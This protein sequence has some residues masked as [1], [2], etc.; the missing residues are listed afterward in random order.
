MR[1][2][3]PIS[4][5]AIFSTVQL[6]AQAPGCPNIDA[7]PDQNIN[8]VG[9]AQ[10]N[11]TVLHTGETNTY[12][13]SSIPYTPP[14]PF[15]T[16]TPILV[17]VDDTWSGVLNLPFNFCFFGNTYNQVV[18]GSNGCLTFNTAN[19]NQYCAWSFSV[20]C[21]NAGIISSSTGPYILGPYHDIDPAVG[22]S[23]YYAILGSYPCRTFVINYY[24]IPMF[25]G[26]C[27]SLLATHQ[28]VLYE[29]TNVVEVYIQNAPVCPTWNSG[30]KV[31]GI[32]NAAG[33][34][35]FTPP[36]RN[37]GPWS[38]S[39]EAWRFTPNGAPNYT[40]EWLL[41]GTQIATGSSTNVSPVDTTTYTAVCTYFNCDGTQ[42]VVT[43]DVTINVT[44]PI[45]LIVDPLSDTICAGESVT[46]SASGA[47]TYQW[48]PTTNLTFVSDSVVIV[49]PPVTT[50]YTLIVT[51]QGQTCTGSVDIQ[52]TV[53]P[54][55][56]VEALA[57]QSNICEGDTTEIYAINADSF[58]WNDMSTANPRLVSP[59]VTTTYTVTGY[60]A[61]GCSNTASITVNVIPIP[62]ITFNP[63]DPSICNGETATITATGANFYM[64]SN[65]TTSNP[66]VVSPESTTTYQVTGTDNTG[67]CSSSAEITVV[68]NE[69]PTSLFSALPLQGCA[70]LTVAF[71]DESLL[72][73]SWL[74]D[75]GDL[76]TSTQQ[77]PSHTYTEPG[78]YDVTL[79]VTSAD[80]CID[81]LVIS[82]LI[83]V[84][85]QPVADFYWFPEIGKT[86]DPTITFYSDTQSQYWLWLFG[87]AT[88]STSPP[89]VVHTFPS[90]EEQYDVTLIVFNDDGC[91][92]TIT[93]I[94]H[95]IDDVL[96]FPNVITPNG[97]GMNDVLEIKNADK[98]PNNVIQVY[99]R[100]G[101]MVFEQQNYD[102]SWDGGNLADGTYYYI[103]KYLDN[104]FQSSLTILRD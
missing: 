55:P 101:K 22:G 38:A 60:D 91:S 23:M 78:L 79:T 27:N 45:N 74:W 70:P 59:S 7:G 62:D 4:L 58:V 28:I 12:A 61:I 89:P 73:A 6:I 52:I 72:A 15:N 44:N 20:T 82:G 80:G 47:Y 35:G 50:T 93:K 49:T 37:T 98:Y 104:V 3:I 18:A 8:C 29:S 53:N 100:W 10:L 39:N 87:D 21:P 95:I 88:E 90:A 97:D 34:L 5:I 43:D 81:T 19:A 51:D 13:V 99:N 71:T 76:T 96:V 65:A 84:F 68:V 32:Q 92:D 57:T 42:V 25:S 103:F 11:A 86:Y 64:W 30:N 63:S 48:T 56:D 54:P 2:I 67:L 31:I 41:G 17:N 75:F 94:V 40:I 83:E 46:I 14:Y 66:L 77:N 24:Q 1:R 33:S 16:G 26:S 102:N 9:N 85:P 69:S 36:G